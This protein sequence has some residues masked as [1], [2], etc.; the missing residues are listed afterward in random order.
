MARV[1]VIEDD[2]DQRRLYVSVLSHNGFD[3][4][5]A[6]D[7]VSGLKMARSERPDVI[8]MDVMM[9]T[10][11]GLIAAQ[12]LACGKATSEIPIVGMTGLTN[13]SEAQAQA[14]GVTTLLHKPMSNQDLVQAVRRCAEA[15]P[16]L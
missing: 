15:Q 4:V 9:P 5:E 2:V 6:K 10:M 7:A 8:L 12:I 14:S 1:L 3:V 16:A 13:I 11:S